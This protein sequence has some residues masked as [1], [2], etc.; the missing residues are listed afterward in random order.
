MCN[1]LFLKCIGIGTGGDHESAELRP[2]LK[3]I[4][5]LDMRQT[6]AKATMMNA[7]KV[8]YEENQK[9]CRSE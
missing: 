5:W 3:L 1:I 2:H 6:A 8:L 4:G 9:D 7:L